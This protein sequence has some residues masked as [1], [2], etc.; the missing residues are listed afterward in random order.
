MYNENFL[1]YVS[2]FGKGEVTHMLKKSRVGFVSTF[3]PFQIE[4]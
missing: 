2:L 4:S 1:F 3:D